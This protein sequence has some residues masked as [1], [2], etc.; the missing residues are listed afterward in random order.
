MNRTRTLTEG[1]ILAALF[2]VILFLTL[3]V[4]LIGG[5]VVWFLPLP[6][7]IYT[8]RHGLKPS[9]MLWIAT[10]FVSFIIGGIV[11][12][13]LALFF[14]SGGIVVGELYRRKKNAFV[15]L[16]GGSLTYI[17]NLLLSF[18]ISILVFGI[19][20]LYTI[21]EMM[22]QSIKTAEQMLSG[23]GQES[24]E[25][26]EPMYEMVERLMYLGPVM[27]ILVGITYALIIQ[28]ISNVV[29]KRL[30]HDIQ[31]FP[32]FRD[33]QFPKSFIWYYLIASIF[34]IVGM[35]EGSTMYIVVWNLFPILDI[36]M[37]VQGLAFI[38]YYCY[39]KGISK[40]IPITIAI[41]GLFLPFVLYIV[42][43]LGIIDLGFDLR[44]RLESH[45]K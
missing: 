40:G 33:W 16:L 5:L 9:F 15:I 12:L 35:E 27:I 32:A 26:L 30:G 4:P 28:L 11:V 3:Y 43:I 19:H 45:K 18:V 36:V 44:K 10:L 29:V 23:L 6:F 8:I 21:Q 20:P 24:T 17:V 22:T 41:V 34:I 31:T 2:A 13:P 7:I 38:F 37:I 42:K 39:A 25:Q 1:A 14:G